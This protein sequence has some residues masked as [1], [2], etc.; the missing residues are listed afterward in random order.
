LEPADWISLQGVA[1]DRPL[2]DSIKQLA[3]GATK[4]LWITSAATETPV[5]ALHT[6]RVPFTETE[7]YIFRQTNFVVT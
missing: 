7:V 5:Q 6:L 4:I 3:S 2:I 1:L